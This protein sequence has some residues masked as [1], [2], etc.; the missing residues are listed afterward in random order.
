MQISAA[1]FRL[2]GASAVT[3]R[4]FRAEDDV[5]NAPKTVVLAYSFWQRRFAGDQNVIGRRITLGGERYEIIGVAPRNLQNGQIAEQSLLSGDIEIN[6][7]P[8]VYI[9]FQIDPH[10]ADRGHYFNVAGRLRPGVTLAAA[11]EQLQASYQ[12]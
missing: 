10:S 2:C 12:E 9:P 8:D 11:N 6:E 3:G 5:P 4:T 7:P 1:F